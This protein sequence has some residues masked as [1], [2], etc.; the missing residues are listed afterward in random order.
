MSALQNIS[1]KSTH[2]KNKLEWFLWNVI[3]VWELW[4]RCGALSRVYC[5]CWISNS[6]I[7][8]CTYSRAD[9]T[10]VLQ[11]F[12]PFD[13]FK[14]KIIYSSV[15]LS[16]DNISDNDSNNQ[17]FKLNYCKNCIL[18]GDYP[19]MYQTV[20]GFR[21]IKNS[22]PEPFIHIT[23]PICELSLSKNCRFCVVSL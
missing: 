11:Y 15:F 9:V 22:I 12:P 3:S 17:R 6:L 10:D 8:T 18:V 5:I 19:N 1:K 21:F 13:Q 7:D 16:F 4:R 2:P 23:E 14:I 20:D